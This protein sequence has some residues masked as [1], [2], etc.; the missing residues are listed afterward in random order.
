MCYSRWSPDGCYVLNTNEFNVRITVWGLTQIPAGVVA[1]LRA[2]KF[3]D[4]AYDFSHDGSY[5][6]VAER[7]NAKDYVQIY[8][9][10]SFEPVGR[11]PVDTRDLA[12]LK[13]APDDTSIGVWDTNLEYS[14]LAYS[15]DGRRLGRFQVT[16]E[17]CT[18]NVCVCARA[19][20]LKHAHNTCGNGAGGR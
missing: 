14:F 13:W 19:C 12:D 15:P 16:S 4:R 2:P 5:L 20:E 18:R 8:Q 6:A 7:K 9:C 17:A 1:S 10:G 11:F 3:C